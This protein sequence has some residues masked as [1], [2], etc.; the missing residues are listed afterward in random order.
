MSFIHLGFLAAGLAVAVPIVIHLLF[1]QKTRDVPIGSI[2]F[3]HQVVKEHRRRR[4]LR[5]WILLAMR[6]LAVLLLAA[7][8]ARPYWDRSQQQ[9]R[10]REVVLLVDKSA[11]MAA[12]GNGADSAFAQAIELLKTELQALPEQVVVHVAFTDGTGVMEVPVEEI[13]KMTPGE[14]GT[15]HT[16]AIE[17]ARDVL[18]QSKRAKRE[19]LYWTDSQRSGL[20]APPVQLPANIALQVRDVGEALPSNLAIL[21]AEAAQTE[22]RPDAAV[23]VRAVVRNFSPFAARGVEINCE[24]Q[25]PTG[26]LVATKEIDLAPNGTATVELPILAQQDGVYRGHLELITTNIG[27][28]DGFALDNRRWLAF[29]ARKPERV[30]LVDGQE[31]RSVFQNETYYLETA[32]RIR[33]EEAGG[34]IRS[35]EPERI[36]W[37]TGKGFP[38][39]DGYRAIV[40]ANIRRITEDDAERL[41]GYVQSG[42]NL[43]IFAGDQVS[44]ASLEP[45]S[46][47]GLLPGDIAPRTVDQSLRVTDWSREHPALILFNDPQQGDLRRI[48]ANTSLPLAKLSAESNPLLRAN[49]H[50]LA[51]ERSVGK[52]LVLYIGF[53]ADRDWTELPQSRLYVPLVRQLL[54]HLTN[55]LQARSPISERLVTKA[56]DRI[57]L[58]ETAG[59][60]QVT[61]L[62]PRESAPERYAAADLQELFG[63]G[64]ETEAAQKEKDALALLLPADSL[65]PEELW[66]LIAWALVI[67]LAAE[68]LLAGRVHA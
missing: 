4:W 19:I 22:I 67:I 34:R 57:G 41:Q 38:R 59:K 50:V 27:R 68:L 65:R 17:W 25:G 48:Q 8:F 53:T 13:A 37:E 51:A 47:K 5:Q 46:T 12:T 62:D 15:D 18:A 3:L 60:W 39:L 6:A 24:L 55:Q 33:S 63:G 21:V 43:L 61:N 14:A 58:I 54:A 56:D 49:E 28:R 29:E 66:Q 2:R 44:A 9:A 42:G 45:L 16:L 11:S 35:F 7:L 10:D 31:G 26:K 30:L 52:G 40:L 32:L 20:N 64:G 36:V 1:R 23:S